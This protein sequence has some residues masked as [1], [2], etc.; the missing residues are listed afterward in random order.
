MNEYFT[1]KNEK[2]KNDF[3]IIKENKFIDLSKA[4]KKLRTEPKLELL[5]CT[6]ASLLET[7]VMLLCLL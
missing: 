1:T 2:I 3:P 4:K 6:H 7:P 5:I